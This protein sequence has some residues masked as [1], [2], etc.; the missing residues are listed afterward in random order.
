ME[1][2]NFKAKGNLK[3]NKGNLKGIQNGKEIKMDYL[4]VIVCY[5]AVGLP[6]V[7]IM[8]DDM[9]DEWRRKKNQDKN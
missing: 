1:V 9:I 7:G 3:A 5:A 6:I 4:L 8:I 2:Q